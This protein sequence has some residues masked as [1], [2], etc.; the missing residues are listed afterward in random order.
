MS[1]VVF[2]DV[3]G[4]LLDRDTY[5]WEAARPAV[6]RLRQRR[7]PLVLCTSKTRVEVEHL[8][9]E[10]GIADPFIVENGSAIVFDDG[11]LTELGLPYSEIRERLVRT[12]LSFSGYGDLSLEEICR[13]TG[14]DPEAARR[15]ARREYSETLFR[16]QEG[17]ET[18][19]AA[20][21]L[22]GVQ[23]T[24]FFTVTGQGADKGRAVRL[25]L[26]KLRED[27]AGLRSIGLGDSPNDAPMLAE[28]D[29]P[30]LVQRP[31]GV[32]AEID[33]P[34]LRRVEGVGPVGVL[35]AVL[36]GVVLS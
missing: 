23:G 21:G 31:G 29:V 25:L 30:V 20:Q 36:G 32:W 9:R 35:E 8:R 10:L 22:F 19:L 33:L 7:I 1:L 26:A 27:D 2:S 13:L 24:R 18:A 12:G 6:E 3:D 11:G 4:T 16:W 14:L 5:S 15:A 17:L 28:V 34:G